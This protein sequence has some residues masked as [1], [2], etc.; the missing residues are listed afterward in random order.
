[1]KAQLLVILLMTLIGCR[2]NYPTIQ[3]QEQLSPVFNYITIDGKEYIDL[4]SSRC[5][6]RTY[7]VD[8]RYVGAINQTIMLDIKECDRVIGYAPREYATFASFL[9][10]MR[11]WLNTFN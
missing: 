11:R 6:S 1:M 4:E 8:R 5:L 10:N 7:R 2:N 3:D 9:E